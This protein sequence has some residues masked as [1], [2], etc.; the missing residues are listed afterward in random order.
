[1]ESIRKL[2]KF[3]KI[4]ENWNNL[5]FLTFSVSISGIFENSTYLFKEDYWTTKSLPDNEYFQHFNPRSFIESL[6]KIAL[7]LQNLGNF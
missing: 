7:K 1:M 2:T 5:C 4:V 6:T 3:H